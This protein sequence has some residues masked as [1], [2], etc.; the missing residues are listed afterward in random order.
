MGPIHKNGHAFTRHGHK[1]L[2][3]PNSLCS[4]RAASAIYYPISNFIF[5]RTACILYEQRKR[6]C[7]RE[8]KKGDFCKFSQWRWAWW[9][10]EM[11]IQPLRDEKGKRQK[12]STSLKCGYRRKG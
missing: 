10:N 11:E 1:V 2:A 4:D 12:H 3:Q 5:Q 6:F 8:T 9:M 7:F